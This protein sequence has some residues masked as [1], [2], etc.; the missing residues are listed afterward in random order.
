MARPVAEPGSVGYLATIMVPLA[1]GCLYQVYINFGERIIETI[2]QN[3]FLE[4]AIGTG[5]LSGCSWLL[6]STSMIAVD[7]IKSKT[8]CSISI[9][10]QD[11]GFKKVIEFIGKKGLAR[12]GS[13]IATTHKKKDTFL[14]W[15]RGELGHTD[16]PKMEYRPDDNDALHVLRYKGARILMRRRKGETVMTGSVRLSRSR[17][18]HPCKCAPNHFW[19]WVKVT[20]SIRSARVLAVRATRLRENVPS[21]SDPS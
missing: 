19:R 17:A 18:C 3:Q 21:L 5:I 14:N 2:S 13:L 20:D 8:L 6:Y 7:S 9:R 15:K 1:F 4:A 12:H 10:S 16:P 11:E